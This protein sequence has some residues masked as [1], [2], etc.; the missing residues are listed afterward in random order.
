ML[1]GNSA[2]FGET[3]N[4]NAPRLTEVKCRQDYEIGA[5]QNMNIVPGMWSHKI[6]SGSW[7]PNTNH[8]GMSFKLSSGEV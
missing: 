2:H 8:L 7:N 4:E 6:Y 5:P 3:Q 1:G